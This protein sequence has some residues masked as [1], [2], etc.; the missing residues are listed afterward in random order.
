MNKKSLTIKKILFFVLLFVMLLSVVFAFTLKNDKE[1]VYATAEL[2]SWNDGTVV[3]KGQSLKIPDGTKILVDGDEVETKELLVIYPD[4]SIRAYGDYALTQEGQY[5]IRFIGEKDGSSY[6]VTKPF[7]VKNNVYSFSQNESLVTYRELDDCTEEVYGLTNGQLE[8]KGVKKDLLAEQG[9]SEGIID[10][11]LGQNDVFKFNKVVNLNSIVNEN[12]LVDICSFV[13]PNYNVVEEGTV[14]EYDIDVRFF[15]V[16]V[17]DAYDPTNYIE[18]YIVPGDSAYYVGCGASNQS[19][20]KGLGDETGP[21]ETD[22][23][24][25]SVDGAWYKA[26]SFER[27][28]TS[29]AHGRTKWNPGR[30]RVYTDKKGL[31]NF[32]L[33]PNTWQCYENGLMINDLDHSSIYPQE[34]ERFKGFTTGEVFIQFECALPYVSTIKGEI[35]SIFNMKGEQLKDE[36]YADTTAPVISFSS[37][38]KSGDRIFVAKNSQVELPVA[39]VVDVNSNG[40]YDVAIYRNYNMEKR[41][42]IDYADN[43]FAP[44]NTGVYTVEY[45]ATD[46]YGN[47]TVETIEFVSVNGEVISYTKNDIAKLNAGEENLIPVLE[48]T[49][50]NANLIQTLV[51]IEPNGKVIDI[52]NNKDG[53]YYKV[54]PEAVGEYTVK[55]TFD[56]GINQEV[57]SYKVESENVNDVVFFKGALAIP[58]NMIRDAYYDIDEYFAYAPSANGLQA[59]LAEIWYSVNGN[60]YQEIENQHKFKLEVAN[61]DFIDDGENVISFKA[62]YNSTYSEEFTSRIIDLNFVENKIGNSSRKHYEKYFYGYDTVGGDTN[63]INYMFD[64]S[65]DE[66]LEFVTPIALGA[67]AIKFEIPEN[68]AN[69]QTLS[70]VIRSISNKAEGYRI[71]YSMTDIE[72][73]IGYKIASLDGKTV[74]MNTEI[75]TKMVGEH[76]LNMIDGEMKSGENVNIAL[77]ELNTRNVEFFFEITN[78]TGDS[79]I[80]VSKI[81][82]QNFSTALRNK[83]EAKAQ[84][85]YTKDNVNHYLGETCR[86][87]NFNVS[88]AFYPT[89]YRDL[90]VTL[91]DQDGTIA[92][93]ENNKEIKNVVLEINK[94][95]YFVINKVGKYFAQF[96]FTVFGQ[97]KQTEGVYGVDAKDETKPEVQF[98]DVTEGYA[99]IIEINTKYTFKDYEAK[100]DTTKTEELFIRYC[101]YLPN[102]NYI[103]WGDA[104][105][106]TFTQTGIYKIQIYCRDAAMNYSTSEYYVSVK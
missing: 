28:T 10:F 62:K 93:D 96:N 70:V 29:L 11:K 79:E 75:S 27:Y 34:Y 67:F 82:N 2:N 8:S 76:T 92:V 47:S 3:L 20:L 31:V 36:F 84:I 53:D 37:N 78:A 72:N 101:V 19:V 71:S 21:S 104:N 25:I 52:S 42:L 5:Q 22:D 105:Y 86:I 33:N 63:G 97:A 99:D 57:Y 87:P 30:R 23:R 15:L 51:L 46:S 68:K 12:G 49:C 85:I 81:C 100:D 77:P 66:R 65:S 44:N 48:T 1:L 18:F 17:V 55:Y 106:F 9:V 98:K 73:K 60:D 41:I 45:T 103:Y 91:K 61:E 7:S 89:T 26:F 39:K 32:S 35:M 80:K 16:K 50:L 83:A 74:Y 43:K 6:S 13:P 95:Y 4:G 58:S 88:C 69:F 40:D 24:I 102:G 64:G 56:D 54:I 38:V 59:N 90:T 14:S 94:D